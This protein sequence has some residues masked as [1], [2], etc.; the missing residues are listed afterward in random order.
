MNSIVFRTLARQTR[1]SQSFFRMMSS[2]T[3]ADG[4]VTPDWLEQHLGKVKVLD[5]NL[6]LDPTKSAEKEFSEKRIPT[7]QY[8]NIDKI[9]DTSVPLPH[10]LS[11]PE[12]FKDC[13]EKLGISST[14]EVVI[15]D[16]QGLFSA[17]RALWMFRVFNP[18]V[19]TYI[20]EGGMPRWLAEGHKL[21]TGPAVVPTRGQFDLEYHK[22]LVRNMD[23]VLD[24]VKQYQKG[25]IPHTIIDAR[26]NPRFTGKVGEA[27]PNLFK[28]HMP[29]SVNIPFTEITDPQRNYVFRS[30][31]ELQDLFKKQNIDLNQKEPLIF[32]CGSGT[33][34]CVD[35]FAAYLCGRRDLPSCAVYDGAWAQYASIPLNNPVIDDYKN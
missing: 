14:D 6:Y 27:R 20:L 5:A 30:K 10:M 35:V 3:P 13:V 16:T 24:L 29:G 1:V 15:Y 32:S 28:G 23:D 34:A 11:T 33:T 2:F 25:K 9:A 17:T 12:F 7:A 8:F 21:E 26:P 22:E 18:N 19:K 31:E 4:V